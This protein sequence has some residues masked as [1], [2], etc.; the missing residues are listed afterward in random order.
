MHE[1]KFLSSWL[2]EDVED[3]EERRRKVNK[4]TR[5]M[6]SRTGKREGRKERTKRWLLKE[7]VSTLFPV[8]QSWGGFGQLWE[9]VG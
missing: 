7:G 2:R 3:E 6:V 1:E 5:E 8:I 9:F 4:E